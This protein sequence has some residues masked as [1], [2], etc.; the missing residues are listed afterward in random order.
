MTSEW[1]NAISISASATSFGS[2]RL[3]RVALPAFISFE[4]K[5]DPVIAVKCELKTVINSD[6]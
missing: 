1:R 3:T 2:T 4:N 5:S 6:E